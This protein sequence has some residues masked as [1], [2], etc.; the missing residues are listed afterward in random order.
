MVTSE[1][2]L[3]SIPFVFKKIPPE[4]HPGSEWKNPYGATL[5][6]ID[7]SPGRICALA[8]LAVASSSM[9]RR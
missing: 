7:H 1:P 4:I 3:Q 9:N 8:I 2:N 5:F 6:T